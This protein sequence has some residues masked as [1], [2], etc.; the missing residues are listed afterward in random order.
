MAFLF[1]QSDS[2]IYASHAG[3][4]VVGPII[5]RHSGLKKR[6]KS[7]PLRHGIPHIDLVRTYLGLLC[8]GKNDFEAVEEV[9]NDLFF[10]QALGIGRMPSSARLRQRFDEQA[11]ELTKA[12]DDCIVPMLKNLRATVT[13]LP[14]GHVALHADV[15]CLD[16]SKTRKEGVARTYHGYDGYAPIGA[17]LG[18]EGW[19]IGLELRP[20]DQH[21]QK[22]FLFFL[23]RILPRARA[24]AGKRP[25]LI[26]L[27]GAHDAAAN[28]EYLAREQIDYL[29]KWNPRKENPNDWQARAEAEQGFVEVRPGKR[30]ALF[31][32]VIEWSFGQQTCRSRRV[33]RLVERTEDRHGQPLLIPDLVLEGWWT[34]LDASSVD[35]EQL[36]RLYQR[37]GT[38]EQFHSEF[39]SDLD[40]VRLPSGKFETNALV[41]ALAALAYNILR[42]IGQNTLIGPDAPIRKALHRRRLRTVMQE[43]IYRA[44]RLVRHGR[45]YLLRFGHGDP[46]YG[47]LA[48][49]H[50]HVLA[51]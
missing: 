50:A 42:Y 37:R 31:D 29:I 18:E 25:L 51:L 16:N 10:K 36:I 28:R 24:L 11:A 43:M 1:E 39:K 22:D 19:S 26:T 20:G 12:A 46:R 27:D 45:R 21:S 17:Y 15:F 2:E 34:S 13:A 48:R 35:A 44:A 5:N 40:L 7:I 9:R 4:A 33:V 3:L 38:S 32:E 8:Q 6:L 23:D 41:L 14:S 30:V 49:C 47:P